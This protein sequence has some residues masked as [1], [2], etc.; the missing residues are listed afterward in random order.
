MSLDWTDDTQRPLDEIVRVAFPSGGVTAGTL[1]RRARKGQLRV[2]KPGKSHL[3]S[4]AAIREMLDACT[5]TPKA[6]SLSSELNRFELA[7]AALD[8]A[9]ASVR[10]R[11]R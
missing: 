10:Q 3:T 1:L 7:S 6:R 11:K 2:T 5:V 8:A 4:L 9:L